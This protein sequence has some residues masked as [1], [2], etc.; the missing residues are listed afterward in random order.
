MSL[1]RARSLVHRH[2]RCLYGRRAAAAHRGD[3]RSRRVPLEGHDAGRGKRLLQ[4]GGTWDAA[5][6]SLRKRLAGSVEVYYDLV[7]LPVH[8]DRGAY[9]LSARVGTALALLPHA[10]GDCVLGV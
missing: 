5:I 6:S 9:V 7:A 8:E 1:E 10:V 4:R 2:H 3:E